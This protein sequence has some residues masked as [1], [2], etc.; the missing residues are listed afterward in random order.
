MIYLNYS[1]ALAMD[2]DESIVIDY[3]RNS[4]YGIF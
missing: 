4:I 2:Y 1:D 3:F